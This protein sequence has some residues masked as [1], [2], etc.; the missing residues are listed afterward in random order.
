MRVTVI[1]MTPG[2]VV[3]KNLAQAHDLIRR[4]S[5][6][7]RPDLIVL[8]EMWSCL[9]GTR[10]AKQA[11]AERLP[12]REACNA[13]PL[14]SAMRSI[15]REFDVVLHGGSIGEKAGDRLYNTTVVFAPNGDELARY[16]KIHLFDVVVRGGA[17]YRESDTFLAGSQ[18]T[19]FRVDDMGIGCSIC[20]DLRFAYLF[21]ALRSAG[22]DLI[23]LPAAFTTETGQAHW[24]V[25]VRARAIETQSWVAAAATTGRHTD[26]NGAQRSTFG[27]SMICDPWG[28]VV[29]QA[30]LGSGW[31]T[32]M[33]DRSVTDQVRRDMPVWQHR[34]SL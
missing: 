9:G 12:D 15:A 31:A 23:L 20:Y 14:Y 19:T 24:D 1:Q 33:I 22:V 32:A 29:A 27:H 7:D 4:A 10:E 3:E 17:E 2:H 18:P 30:S 16:R 21:D 34:K 13:G 25:L 5:Q 6:S 28:T 8:P 11:A 26:G